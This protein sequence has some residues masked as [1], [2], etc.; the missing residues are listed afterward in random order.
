M[1]AS[2]KSPKPKAFSDNPQTFGEHI[3]RARLLAGLSQPKLAALLRVDAATVLNWEKDRTEPPV[4]S[5]PAILRFIGYDPFPEPKTIGE[6][7]L[8]K[9]RAMGWTIREAA[10]K[11]GVDEGTWGDWER[12]K[13]ILYR[14]YREMVA[15]FL[16]ESVD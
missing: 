6:R 5:Y 14:R 13:A 11:L 15:D 8:A 12:G 1:S 3:K 7:M 9:R 4:T 16:G 2:L 10:N